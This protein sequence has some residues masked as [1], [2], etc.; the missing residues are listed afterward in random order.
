MSKVTNFDLHLMLKEIQGDMKNIAIGIELH[1][2]RDKERFEE[3]NKRVD[4]INKY[5][6]TGAFLI[7][8]TAAKLVWDKVTT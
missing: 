3:I 7:I 6:L 8:C 4:V 5:S 2:E 1:E